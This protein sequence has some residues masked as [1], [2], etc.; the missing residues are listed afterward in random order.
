MRKSVIL[1]LFVSLIGI[2]ST[3][4]IKANGPEE[5]R[6]CVVSVT[7]ETILIEGGDGEVYVGK[8]A[9]VDLI[10]GDDVIFVGIVTPSGRFIAIKVIKDDNA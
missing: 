4:V 5:K 7:N 6:G 9:Q 2:F 10:V 3:S 1:A 8:A